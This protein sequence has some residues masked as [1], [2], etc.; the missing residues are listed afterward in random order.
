MP[1]WQN[2]KTVCESTEDVLAAVKEVNDGN[3][4]ISNV[5][6]TSETIDVKALY[7]SID[8]ETA[9]KVLVESF[10]NSDSEIKGINTAELGLY[11]AVNKDNQQKIEQ[12]GLAAFC[13]T[14][15]HVRRRKRG[16]PP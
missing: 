7:P 14:R 9:T 8:T 12:M 15:R 2:N 11:R 4:K 10:F 3:A 5:S 6:E 13:P 1:I 16:L